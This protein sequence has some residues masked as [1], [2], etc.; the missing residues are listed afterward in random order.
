LKNALEAAES[1][2]LDLPVTEKVQEMIGS[3]VSLGKG[4]DD[5]G[6][7]IQELERQNNA[8]VQGK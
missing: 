5:H 8:L 1:L 7:I 4:D 3:L 6:G 2:N